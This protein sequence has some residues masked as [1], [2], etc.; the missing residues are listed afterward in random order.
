MNNNYSNINDKKYAMKVNTDNYRIFAILI[1]LSMNGLLLHCQ[2]LK[3]V[4]ATSQG[5]AGGICC[6]TGVNY[7]INLQLIRT[8]LPIILDTIWLEG[9][10]R[11][12][13]AYNTKKEGKTDTVNIF[14]QEGWRTN[15]YEIDRISDKE[16]ILNYDE[17]KTGVKVQYRLGKQK[18]TLDIT[19]FLKELEFIAYP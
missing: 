9:Y 17:T 18:L 12:L 15:I 2:S 11:D 8:K 6:A 19:P 13:S 3:V 14:I 5:W 10:P 7:H 4:S 16:F 1:F